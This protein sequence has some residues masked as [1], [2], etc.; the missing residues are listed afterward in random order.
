M[1]VLNVLHSYIV[2]KPYTVSGPT[3]A[4]PLPPLSS[5]L[6]PLPHA[7]PPFPLLPLHCKKLEDSVYNPSYSLPIGGF[8]NNYLSHLFGNPPFR[9]IILC[10]WRYLYTFTFCRAFLWIASLLI[11]IG[12]ALACLSYLLPPPLQ[13]SLY[14][15]FIDSHFFPLSYGQHSII[16]DTV[17][18][19]VNLTQEWLTFRGGDIVITVIH[20]NIWRITIGGYLSI[21]FL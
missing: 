14:Y 18:S 20:V 4:H 6:P 11:L 17:M 12:Y 21:C 15:P 5:C 8:S 7:H 13:P 19:E 16:Y 9:R 2:Q 10:I 1:I 3:P